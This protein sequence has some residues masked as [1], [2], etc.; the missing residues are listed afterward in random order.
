MIL[1][2]GSKVVYPFHGPCRIDA[3]VWKDFGNGPTKCYLLNAMDDSGNLMFVPI[4]KMTS[5]GFRSLMRTSEVAKLLRHLKK[6][7]D[8]TSHGMMKWRQ[9]TLEHSKLLASGSVIDLA[10]IIVPLTKLDR[11]RTLSIRDR[12]ALERAKKH[13]ICEVA[14]ATGSTKIITKAMID[15]ALES[16]Q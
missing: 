6:N 5:S 4:E 8:H 3:L 7:V 10:D 11:V 16:L 2:I 1:S 12:A 9:R 13:L 15:N 14:E